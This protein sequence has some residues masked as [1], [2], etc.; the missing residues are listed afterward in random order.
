MYLKLYDGGLFL[1][2]QGSGLFLGP[3]S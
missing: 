3:K 1:G 2:L